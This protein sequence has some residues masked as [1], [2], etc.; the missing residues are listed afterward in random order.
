M[1][2]FISKNIFILEPRCIFLHTQIPNQR[3]SLV[4]PTIVTIGIKHSRRRTTS[5]GESDTWVNK[6]CKCL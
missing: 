1:S 2:K 3:S 6:N 4:N 5:F